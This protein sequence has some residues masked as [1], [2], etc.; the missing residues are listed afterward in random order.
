MRLYVLN[1][2]EVLAHAEKTGEYGK[3]G[4]YGMNWLLIHDAGSG[5]YMVKE[6][7]MEEYLHAVRFPDYWKPFGANAPDE[8]KFIGTTETAT[9]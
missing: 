3:Y 4:D 6:M 5:P 1:K 2:D 8:S 9:V 7:K